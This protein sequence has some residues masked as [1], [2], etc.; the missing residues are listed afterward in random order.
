VNGDGAGAC[1][2]TLPSHIKLGFVAYSDVEATTLAT[3]GFIASFCTPDGIFL[4]NKGIFSAGLGTTLAIQDE[5]LAIQV[6]STPKAHASRGRRTLHK[7]WSETGSTV[8]YPPPLA[9][10]NKFFSQK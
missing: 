7:H 10:N 3:F 1:W 5:K 8:P 2:N 9:V 4:A 6:R